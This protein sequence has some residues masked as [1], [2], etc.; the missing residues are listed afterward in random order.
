[1]K[2]QNLI[3]LHELRAQEKAI[4][5]R[6]EQISD[7]ATEEELAI[8]PKSGAIN[9]GNT[10]F[11]A[12]ITDV[13]DMSNY[14]R[15]KGED[16]KQWRACDAKQAELKKQSAALTKIK[17]GLVDAFKDNNPDWAPDEVKVTIKCIDA[18]KSE[19]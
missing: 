17:A 10:T 6:I 8:T 3:E 18:K 5:A 15:Y 19:E 1:M 2:N 9:V 13:I 11:Q 12:Q 14:N 4:K 7:K 16:G